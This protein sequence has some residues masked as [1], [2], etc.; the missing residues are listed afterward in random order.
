MQ[1][2]KQWLIDVGD[3]LYYLRLRQELRNV[4]SVLDVGCG[5]RS[6]LRRIPKTFASVGVDIFQPSIDA[7]RKNNIHDSYVRC[8]VMDID[9]KF[10]KNSFDAVI[11]LDLIEHIDKKKG[12]ALLSKM[13]H[14]ACRKVILLT[15][16]GFINQDPYEDNPYQVHKSGWSV[17]DFEQR[18]YTVRGLRGLRMLRGECATIRFRPW[19]FWS[20]IAV[21]TEYVLYG[22]PRWSNQLFAVKY[23][24]NHGSA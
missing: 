18:G 6:P 3:M 14:I 2:I 17:D 22:F 9:K 15:P 24:N 13:E 4:A 12:S 19:L 11:A 20:V 1:R 16:N 5:A 21:L 23:V 10:K 7:S 8:D